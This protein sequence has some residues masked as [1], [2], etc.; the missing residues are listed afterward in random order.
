[1]NDAVLKLYD[2]YLKY[3]SNNAVAASLTLADLMQRTLV[4]RTAEPPR[5]E[6]AAEPAA[7]ADN[8][9]MMV[10]EVARFLRVR[11]D[12]V[13]SWIRSGRLR[14]YN[15]A[16]HETGR[17]K[18]RV[19]PEDLEAFMLMRVP[20]QPTPRGRPIGRHI[21]RIPEPNWKP[22]SERR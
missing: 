6:P 21:R 4:A 17:P 13:L 7:P 15:V 2:T 8:R 12:K 1:M 20:L 10:P 22:K 19:N 3:T 14:G 9:P 5:A 11:P 18:Y 16:E